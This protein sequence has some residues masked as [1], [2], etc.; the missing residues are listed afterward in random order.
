MLSKDNQNNSMNGWY[1]NRDVQRVLLSSMGLN[2]RT[3]FEAVGKW[4]IDNN[5]YSTI[6]DIEEEFP[7]VERG[8]KKLSESRNLR[9]AFGN[10]L[11][12]FVKSNLALDRVYPVSDLRGG[13]TLANHYI[14]NENPPLEIHQS[15]IGKPLERD[16][17][18]LPSRILFALDIEM[19]TTERRRMEKYNPFFDELNKARHIIEEEL[20][21]YQIPNISILTGR[22]FHVVSQINS[23][24]SL[25]TRLI[26]DVAIEPTVEQRLDSNEFFKEFG[27]KVPIN[28]ERAL[29]GVMRLQQYFLN[30]VKRKMPMKEIDAKSSGDFL[31]LD[32]LLMLRTAFIAAIRTP[33]ST[34]HK[35]YREG[36]RIIV[37]LTL[38]Y[39][40]KEMLDLQSA[41]KIRGDIN[42]ALHQFKQQ[43]GYIPEGSGG[44]ERLFNE[45][46]E[47][48]L[49]RQVHKVMDSEIPHPLDQYRRDDYAYLKPI[50][51][52]VWDFAPVRP[53]NIINLFNPGVLHDF[54]NGLYAS[55]WHPKHIAGLMSAIYQDPRF[56]FGDFFVKRDASRHANGWVEII[57]GQRYEG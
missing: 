36:G 23:S 31:S 48:D 37:P 8:V 34:Y 52:N 20:L 54:V 21:R 26:N 33:S 3:I 14:D 17:T 46:L 1:W 49:Y 47:S 6:R 41:V 39:N 57:L 45:Y 35:F 27:Y 30:K 51:G 4:E 24:S 19:E 38:S 29:K 28:A 43:V 10:T 13:I 40:G 11:S 50:L 5:L 2:D 7:G 18:L 32:F 53:N 16:S 25:M 42:A 56:N 22:G 44:L 9:E 12:T 15:F 55:H